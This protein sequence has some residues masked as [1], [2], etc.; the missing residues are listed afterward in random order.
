MRLKAV[1]RIL[2]ID[3]VFHTGEAK[4]DCTF[5]DE[6]EEWMGFPEEMVK[7]A[8]RQFNP[9]DGEAVA[10]IFELSQ[11][12]LDFFPSYLVELAL[13]LQ[14][15]LK[16]KIYLIWF[17][18]TGHLTV[19]QTSISKSNETTEKLI[20]RGWPGYIKAHHFC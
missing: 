20:G 1:V 5:G 16:Q 13:K 19:I 10:C 12:D 17:P 6:D 18:K 15:K 11:A 2:R 4:I 7:A 3:Q 8:Y 9:I 14:K